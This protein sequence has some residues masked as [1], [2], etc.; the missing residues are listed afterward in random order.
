MVWYRVHQGDRND[1]DSPLSTLKDTYR[2]YVDLCHLC[3]GVSDIVYRVTAYTN[4]R[5]LRLALTSAK[6]DDCGCFKLPRIILELWTS[7]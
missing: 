1:P 5:Y 3:R 7:A 4:F 2:P 6:P